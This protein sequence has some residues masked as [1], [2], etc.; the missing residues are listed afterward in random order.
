M[1]SFRIGH[2]LLL[3]TLLNG[4]AYSVHQVAVSSFEP[5][6]SLK[7]MKEIQAEGEQF[8]ILGFAG[9]TEYVNQT[10]KKLESQCRGPIAG[11]VTRYS[12]ALGF[13]S[14]HNH[15]HMSGWCAST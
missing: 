7:S 4:C 14:W 6:R 11:V 9:D 10:R 13:F 3:V 12:T 15:I 5:Y 2:I 8:V 1:K